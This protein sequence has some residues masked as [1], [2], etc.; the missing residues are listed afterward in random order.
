MIDLAPAAEL[1]AGAHKVMLTCHLGPDGDALGSMSALAALLA[2]AGKAVVLYNPDPAPKP[3]RGLPNIDKL[4]RQ[5]G[6]PHDVTIVVDC[7]DRKLLG[8]R[9][10]VGQSARDRSARAKDR[11]GVER[12]HP[13]LSLLAGV[14][15]RKT[16]RMAV[17]HGN[18]HDVAEQPALLWRRR[19]NMPG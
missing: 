9:F 5:P 4:S 7:G 2:A 17:F 6:G 16:P 12:V 13:W 18:P 11:G 8:P 19:H 3:L 10:V 14:D 1:L 15:L